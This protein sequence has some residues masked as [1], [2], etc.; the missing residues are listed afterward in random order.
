MSSVSG[1]S[2]SRQNALVLRRDILLSR[3]KEE[4]H[5][6]VFNE[7]PIHL[8]HL[9]SA[10]LCDRQTVFRRI[11]PVFSALTGGDLP[12]DLNVS[13]L[14]PVPSFTDTKK[15]HNFIR[16]RLGYAV[17]SDHWGEPVPAYGDI[18]RPALIE[19]RPGYYDVAKFCNIAHTHNMEYAWVDSCCID[20]SSDAELNQS[21][22]SMYRWYGNSS[23]CI[24]H[25]ADSFFVEELSQDSW[26]RRGW[27]LMQLLAPE[28]LKFY[29]KTWAPLTERSNDKKSPDVLAAIQAATSI[30]PQEL[31]QFDPRAFDTYQVSKRMRWAANR[32][33]PLAED[34]AYSLMGVFG[35]VTDVAYGEGGS[36]AF[37]KLFR[38]IVHFSNSPEVVNW[39]GKP[40]VGL[41]LRSLAYPPFPD[42][43][44]GSNDMVGLIR[45]ESISLTANGLSI[46]LLILPATLT[47]WEA[48]LTAVLRCFEAQVRAVCLPDFTPGDAV[49]GHNVEFALGGWNFSTMSGHC[50]L[51]GDLIEAVL[52][53]R[54]PH[55]RSYHMIWR[56]IPTQS[57]IRL[58]LKVIDLPRGKRWEDYV[59]IAVL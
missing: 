2:A 52:L 59:Q 56:R 27:T 24:V 34:R 49:E 9:Q 40:A 18:P 39:V 5:R 3:V 53:Y 43:F 41:S 54:I 20:R 50:Q 29:D 33:T 36:R 11:L 51:S 7:L 12:E 48:P 21:I 6:Y 10:Q 19:N 47:A 42:A 1:S 16:K 26:F 25:L 14:N 17:L 35:V 45:E 38:E 4:L 13:L 46:K 15:I 44:I 55:Q 32:S 22:R 37:S 57:F 23:I 28:R 31:Q 8:I 58:G 30:S